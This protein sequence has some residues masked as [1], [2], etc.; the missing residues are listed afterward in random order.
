[1][2][3][4]LDEGLQLADRIQGAAVHEDRSNLDNLHLARG[5]AALLVAGG[6]KSMTRKW[7]GVSVFICG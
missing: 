2:A 6:L 3:H 1:M 4:R 5:D 7:A